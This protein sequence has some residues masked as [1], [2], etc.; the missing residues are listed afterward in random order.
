LQTSYNIPDLGKST[1]NEFRGHGSEAW[2]VNVQI[3]DQ[4]AKACV[5]SWSSKSSWGGNLSAVCCNTEQIV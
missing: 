4:S 3:A 5:D 1:V 2:R